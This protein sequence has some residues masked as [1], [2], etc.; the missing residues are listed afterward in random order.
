MVLADLPDLLT[1]RGRAVQ[2]A[3]EPDRHRQLDPGHQHIAVQLADL[4]VAAERLGQQLLRPDHVVRD[5]RQTPRPVHRVRERRGVPGPVRLVPALLQRGDRADRVALQGGHMPEHPQRL[6]PRGVVRRLLRQ[7]MVQ[8]VPALREASAA[9]PEEPEGARQILREMRFARALQRIL[10]R[11]PQIRQLALHPRGH[12]AL[13]RA[14]PVELAP[15][16]KTQEPVPV[17]TSQPVRVTGGRQPLGAVLPHRVQH[18]V[19]GA[20]R[21]VLPYDDGLREQS[22][23]H[24]E[25]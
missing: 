15:G 25:H 3:V 9:H 5:Q 10:H 22:G 18:P 11:P 19:A 20:G 1:D 23:E 7:H 24:V 8:P 14:E 2:I 21:R 6:E 16:G 13:P 17:A 4:P 12:L